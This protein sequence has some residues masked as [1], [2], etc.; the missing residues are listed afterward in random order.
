MRTATIKRGPGLRNDGIVLVPA[1]LSA[2]VPAFLCLLECSPW[3]HSSPLVGLLPLPSRLRGTQQ[4]LGLDAPL[5][6]FPSLG[7]RT[8][9]LHLWTPLLGPPGHLF[10]VLFPPVLASFVSLSTGWA[11]ATAFTATW[12]SVGPPPGVPCL[13]WPS[14]GLRPQ[15]LVGS[16]SG[17]LPI[18]SGMLRTHASDA[19]RC[20]FP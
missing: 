7:L 9:P 11:S 3:L 5:P 14:L 1:T 15:C 16:W 12:H 13:L 6:S 17:L 20:E 10:G 2:L 8:Q 4:A 19:E 18:S